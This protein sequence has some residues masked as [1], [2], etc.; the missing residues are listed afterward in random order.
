M[1][2]KIDDPE[3]PAL[4][5]HHLESSV[6]VEKQDAAEVARTWSRDIVKDKNT[7]LKNPL[8]GLSREDLYRDVEIFARESNLVDIVEELKRGALVA[9]DP[10]SFEQLSELSEEEKELLR[11]EK[12]HRWNQ[13]WM[14]YFMT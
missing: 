4:S 14:M 1:D 7:K 10:R 6:S 2:K 13:P 3:A 5:S 12:T 8:A 11:R 9:Q